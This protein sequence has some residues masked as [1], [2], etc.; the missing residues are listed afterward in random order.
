M[1]NK[2]TNTSTTMMCTINSL[3]EI[4][5]PIAKVPNLK[6]N[7]YDTVR[8][9]PVTGLLHWATAVEEY[10]VNNYVTSGGAKLY[11]LDPNT[12]VK[13]TTI[14]VDLDNPKTNINVGETTTLTARVYPEYAVDSTVEWKS[15]NASVATVT[16]ED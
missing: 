5:V 8:Y 10:G 3:G 2:Q 1:A 13:V 16:V 9:N 15:S 6:L 11:S 12:P 4:V 7:A 14:R